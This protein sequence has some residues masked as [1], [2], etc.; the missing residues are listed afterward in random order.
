MENPIDSPI[1]LGL[2][3][4]IRHPENQN[5]VVF[6]FADPERAKSFEEELVHAKI[7]FEKG[8]KESKSKSY[9]LFGIHKQDYKRVEKINYLVEAKHK[10]P[11]IPWK[12]F[13]YTILIISA[14]AM[15][16]ALMGYCEAQKKL[17]RINKSYQTI[18]KSQVDK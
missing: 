9:T 12:I 1:D 8:E 5:Y 11:I 16:M 14:I 17:N 3:N 2:V 7:W 10:K 6:R 13:R 4:Y 15:T 18:S